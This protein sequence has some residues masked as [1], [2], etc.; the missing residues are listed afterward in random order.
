MERLAGIALAGLLAGTGIAGE[1][2][3]PGWDDVQSESGRV[4]AVEG[5]SGPEAVRYDPVQ[6][7]YFVSNFNGEPSGDANGFISR[8][9]PD[10]TVE[11]LKFMVGTEDHPLHGPRGMQIVGDVLWVADAGG[12]H[13]L[14]RETGAHRRFVD[15]SGH[16]PEF[17]ND[18]DAA[19][20][21]SLYVTDTGNARVFRVT[22]GKIEVVASNELTSPPNGITWYSESEGY[23]LAP[24]DGGTILEAYRPASGELAR[25]G[26][27]PGG[28][29][30]DGIEEYRGRLLIASQADQ[31]IWWWRDGEAERLIE[32][33]GRPADIGI[34]TRRQ[35]VAVPYIALDRVDIWQL[36]DSPP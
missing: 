1:P 11:A 34:D 13:G 30:F 36:P 3:S 9:A 5:L 22:D 15:F 28:G 27:M 18:I 23:I 4:A 32:T 16:A 19:P 12:L 2:E 6:D 31:A 14:D 8:V 25:I 17:L 29:N 7:V 21:G 24:W 26:G 35:R 10:G 20:D 33:P